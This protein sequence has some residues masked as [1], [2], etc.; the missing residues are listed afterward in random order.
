MKSELRSQLVRAKYVKGEATLEKIREACLHEITTRGYHRTSVCEVVR[1]ANL[2]RGA[3]YNYWNS[4]DDCLAD[5][6]IAIRD[7]V[8][9]DPDVLEFQDRLQE[10]SAVV[11]KVK[12]SLFLVLEKQNR[13]VYLPLAL[14]QE[15]GLPNQDLL[16]LLHE[17]VSLVRE[18]WAA[19]VREDQ[20]EGNVIP[21][22]DPETIAVVIMN[23][24]GGIVH[25]TELRFREM[26]DGLIDGL[27]LFLN[28]CLTE[29]YREQHPLKALVPPSFHYRKPIVIK[30]GSP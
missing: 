24:F 13:Y 11:R 25:N 1:R 2:T 29:T 16:A 19:A 23:M 10:T 9:G 18:E 14:L 22:L 3:F 20:R 6:I 26:S 17:Y 21:G 30:G 27:T 4:L 5:L 7:S 28:G 12:T 15:K 8:R